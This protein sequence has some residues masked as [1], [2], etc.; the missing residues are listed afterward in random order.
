MLRKRE[1]G[2]CFLSK[3]RHGKFPNVQ[4]RSERAAKSK[5]QALYVVGQEGKRADGRQG[6]GDRKQ[7]MEFGK[8]HVSVGSKVA[9]N[10]PPEPIFFRDRLNVDKRHGR[11]V[12]TLF[13]TISD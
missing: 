6:N 1:Y 3:D 13:I 7:K 12:H 4:K 5:K 11:E 2:N 9:Q 10:G 8:M